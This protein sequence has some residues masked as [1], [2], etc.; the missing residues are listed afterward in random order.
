L[1]KYFRERKMQEFGQSQSQMTTG[2]DRKPG[3]L[4]CHERRQSLLG[5]LAMGF[6]LLSLLGGN[7]FV[8]EMAQPPRHQS[9]VWLKAMFEA[10]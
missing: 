8:S 6:E 7:P 1:E 4:C 2:A 10:S 9:T 3:S 5:D